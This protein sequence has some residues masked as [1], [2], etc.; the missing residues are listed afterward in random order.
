MT[1]SRIL[2][3]SVWFLTAAA[4]FHGSAAER[5]TSSLPGGV[6]VEADTIRQNE[7]GEVVLEGAVTFTW[8]NS[9]FQADH[10]VFREERFIE[11][12]GNVLVV[13]GGNRLSG[14]RMTYD[15]EL[16]TG[17]IEEAR[18]E[19][20][21]EF[22]VS[23][24][25][26]RK[27]GEDRL[28][29]ESATVTTCTQPL[30]YWSFSVSSANIRLDHYAH[31]RN[32]RLKAGKAPVFYLPYMVWPVKRDRS[33]GLLF[34]DFGSTEERGNVLAIPLF[35]PLGHS[36][37]VTVVGEYY[38]EAGLGVGSDFRFVPN[39]HGAGSVSGFYIDDKVAGPE[40][41]STPP[42]PRWR[43]S[44]RETQQFLNG[45]RMIADINQVS[46]FNYFS[47]FE[48]DIRLVSSPSI[49]GRLEFSRNG[50]W[51]S[52]NIRD[53]R[54]EQ[55]VFAVDAAGLPFQSTL[56]QQTLPEVELR[57]RDRRLGKSPFYLS[58]ESSLASIQQFGPTIDA[59]YM[60]LDLFPRLTVPLSSLPWLEVNPRVDYRLTY[61][62]Q[63]QIPGPTP[64]SSIVVDQ[65]LTRGIAAAGI[66]I[67]GPKFSRIFRR[68]ET[69]ASYKN[70]IEPRILY[71]FRE[72]FDDA[73]DVILYDQVDLI[74]PE[75]F[76]TYSIRS[77]LFAK[78]PRAESPAP[79]GGGETIVWP[80]G[81]A[82]SAAEVEPFSALDPRGLPDLPTAGSGPAEPVEIATVELSQTRSIDDIL[83][84]A[85]LDGDGIAEKTSKNS[86]VT[87]AG[88]YN[89]SPATS[90]DLRAN[91]HPIYKQIQN[92]TFSGSARGRNAR[93]GFSLVHNEG[94]ACAV[95]VQNIPVVN[96]DDT[97]LALATGFVLFEGKLRLDLEGSFQ[98]RGQ[99]RVIPA[100]PN[101]PAF[102]RSSTTDFPQKRYR[103]EY[104]TQCCGFLAEYFERDYV[105]SQRR[106]FRFTVDLRG[107]GKFLDLHHGED[108]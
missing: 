56:V 75:N 3:A 81:D 90:L 108:D 8:R 49:L 67:A 41:C 95:G 35:V 59:D 103:I 20:E 30:P 98:Y 5:T 80:S 101:E 22:F 92:V 23:A 91:Y 100:D 39:Q 18:G 50:A 21:P 40:V 68:D 54:R 1:G 13:W 76:V 85:D 87:L 70:L 55:L 14:K 47:D 24:K 15:L 106:D 97:Q 46:D 82:I 63:S 78:R 107:I 65:D 88:R 104:Y 19:I 48:R 10:I 96:P 69:K 25:E 79:L 89:P 86:P 16:D 84:C 34:P 64:A 62:T 12:E 52:V 11:A 17:L 32:M 6:V 66:E 36:A 74:T 33:A 7:Q 99:G 45:F 60:R 94:Q 37:D 44:Y 105:T 4:A 26:I 83:I 77:L 53:F 102:I 72:S 28:H 93:V 61:Y 51:T 42:C 29:L 38:T 2:A 58:Y 31:L 27:V 73:A 57:G 71:G 43:F 9:V